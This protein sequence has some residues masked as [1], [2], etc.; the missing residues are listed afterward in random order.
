MGKFYIHTRSGT[1]KAGITVG[2]ILGY[3]KY[4][5]PHM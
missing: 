1:Q 5:L 2:K 3:D 4:L